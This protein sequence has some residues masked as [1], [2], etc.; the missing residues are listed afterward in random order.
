MIKIISDYYDNNSTQYLR[1]LSN[2]TT[3]IISAV[4]NGTWY[5]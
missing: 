2:S 4:L 1:M 5:R 3:R